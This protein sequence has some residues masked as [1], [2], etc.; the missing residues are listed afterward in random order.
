MCP[1]DIFSTFTY[2]QTPSN[3]NKK[4][5]LRIRTPWCYYNLK[6]PPPKKQTNKQT[7][8]PRSG[9]AFVLKCSI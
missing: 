6:H 7:N 4:Y 9:N 5:S 8:N 1:I 2:V 3:H